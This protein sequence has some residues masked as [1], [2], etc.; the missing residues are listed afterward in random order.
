VPFLTAEDFGRSENRAI[1]AR[2]LANAEAGQLQSAEE[3]ASALGEPLGGY[4]QQLLAQTAEG[5][6]VSEEE[7]SDDLARCALRLKGRSLRQAVDRLYYLLQEPA[8]G[9][10]AEQAEAYAELARNYMASISQI[11]RTLHARTMVGRRQTLE[12]EEH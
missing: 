8:E 4:I 5:P 10:E 3:L 2:I 7:L 12:A 6:A 11:D 9:L 1:F